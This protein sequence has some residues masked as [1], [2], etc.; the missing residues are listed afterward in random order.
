MRVRITPSLFSDHNLTN[1]MITATAVWI[2][3]TPT[4]VLE[5]TL[6]EAKA[7]ISELGLIKPETSKWTLSQMKDEIKEYIATKPIKWSTK[8]PDAHPLL[9]LNGYT[10]GKINR[11]GK[12]DIVELYNSVWQSLSPKLTAPGNRHWK[13][14]QKELAQFARVDPRGKYFLCSICSVALIY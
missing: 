2:E 8:L 11:T 14:L 1:S 13:E 7:W 4:M 10:Q 5:L 12:S 6:D 9:L 3:P